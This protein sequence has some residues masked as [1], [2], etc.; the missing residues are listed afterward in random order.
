ML[1]FVLRSHSEDKEEDNNVKGVNAICQELSE[2]HYVES[3]D[4]EQTISVMDLKLN[5]GH[6]AVFLFGNCI[7]GKMLYVCDF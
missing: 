4:Y 3:M 1:A 7:L 6:C 5:V 2:S